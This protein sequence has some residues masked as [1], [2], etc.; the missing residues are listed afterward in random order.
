MTK[1]VRSSMIGVALAAVRSRRIADKGPEFT[2]CK[3]HATA[4][5]LLVSP[6]PIYLDQLFPHHIMLLIQY[7]SI[8]NECLQLTLIL[9]QN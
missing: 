2:S 3:K 7:M 9:N 5:H 1:I 4:W 8:I 6:N